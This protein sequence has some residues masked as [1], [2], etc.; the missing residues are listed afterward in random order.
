MA[1]RGHLH[2][3]VRRALAAALFLVA[4]LFL[5]IGAALMAILEQSESNGEVIKELEVGG[6][7]VEQDGVRTWRRP[8]ESLEVWGVR[9]DEALRRFV[10]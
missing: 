5:A 9:H 3:M 7:W 4:A 10:K 2:E 6:Q 8:G 1:G